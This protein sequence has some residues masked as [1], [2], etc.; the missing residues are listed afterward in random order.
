MAPFQVLGEK[1]D[2]TLCV[3]ELGESYLSTKT[4]IVGEMASLAEK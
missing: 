3:S 2:P 4:G 1:I